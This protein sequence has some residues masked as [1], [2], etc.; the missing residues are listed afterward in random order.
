[1]ITL[2][3]YNLSENNMSI[4]YCRIQLKYG[5]TAKKGDNIEKA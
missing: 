5:K 1:M 2:T 3:Q 4:L